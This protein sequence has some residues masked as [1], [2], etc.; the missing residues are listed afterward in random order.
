M[1]KP[2]RN[3]K[4]Y[5]AAGGLI[6][7]AIL[8]VSPIPAFAANSCG[9]GTGDGEMNDA[10]LNAWNGR[11]MWCTDYVGKMVKRYYHDNA[12]DTYPL[13]M[14]W[15][16]SWKYYMDHSPDYKKVCEV[17]DDSANTS[18]LKPGDIIVFWR[19]QKNGGRRFLHIALQGKKGRLMHHSYAGDPRGVRNACTVKYWLKMKGAW[20]TDGYIA[21][22]PVSKKSAVK[23][24]FRAGS[25]KED[26]VL[27]EI[28]PLKGARV[29]F[30]T[31]KKN[32]EKN[33]ECRKT[34]IVRKG[35][36]GS[37]RVLAGKKYYWKTSKAPRGYVRAGSG[38]FSLGYHK[39]RLIRVTLKPVTGRIRIL[40]QMGKD[41][42]GKMTPDQ[43]AV[44]RVWN[45]KYKTYGEARR[46]QK[47][48]NR[49]SD[50]RV[51]AQVTL[52]QEGN[53]S[54]SFQMLYGKY[55]VARV[56]GEF[57]GKTADKYVDISGQG[58]AAVNAVV[59]PAVKK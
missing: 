24:V 39:S 16:P 28:L 49:V 18:K 51:C 36:Q 15:V 4:I 12:Y 29:Q 25:S 7:A 23:A 5:P 40:S 32:R 8:A 42:S 1:M 20:Y 26:P 19:N 10:R 2:R 52:D 6:L 38:T 35:N 30:Y 45:V 33:R 46:V 59:N 55:R 41:S 54:T 11:V 48:L 14:R 31:S 50:L 34:L 22:R 13:N 53:G 27:R 21:Y 9:W 47:K 43:S 3:R 56:K 37:G 57:A 17:T 44:Y 58:D